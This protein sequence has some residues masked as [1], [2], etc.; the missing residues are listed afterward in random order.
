M[1]NALLIALC[2][3][4]FSAAAQTTPP[5]DAA[6]RE[7]L[8]DIRKLMTLTGGDKMANQMLDQ[9]AQS[10]RA[11]GGPDF[12]KYFAEFRKEFDLNKVFDLQ[13]GAYDKYL[14]DE[15]VKAMVAFYESPAGKRMVEA[16]PQI[17]GDMMKGAMQISQEIAA[18]VA[19]KVKDQ[20]K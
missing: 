8:A 11:Q 2:L 7:K 13:I 19:Q 17:M 15:D 20:Q 14:S 4:S 9:M 16:M 12:D 10:M 3:L 5:A 1:K 6:H 18:K